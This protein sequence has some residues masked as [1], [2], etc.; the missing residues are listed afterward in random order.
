[1]PRKVLIATPLK[2]DLPKSYFLSSLQL[3]GGKLP[4]VKLDWT[5]LDGPAVQVARNELA[6][7]AIKNGFDE[8]VFWDKDVLAEDELDKNVTSGA[9]V[10]LLEHDV[11]MVCALYANRAV[12]THWHV[13]TIPGVEADEATGLQKVKRCAI[14]FSKIK[15]SALKKV[16]KDNPDRTMLVIDPSNPPHTMTEFFPMGISGK[17]TPEYRIKQIAAAIAELKEGGKDAIP[18]ARL[19]RELTVQYDEP[20]MFLG[21]DYW[22]CEMMRASGFEIYLDTLLVMGH[23]AQVTLPLPTS[24]LIKML[25]EEW[26]QDEVVAIKQ[27]MIAER[28]KIHENETLD[29]ISEAIRQAGKA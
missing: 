11:D 1:M 9:L 5:I 27:A 18:L 16:A 21:E 13:Q 24:K 4:D 3:Y 10:R 25:S 12:M 2:G 23:R 20:N 29:P 14:G 22:F 28:K 17:N 15:V 7:H 19:E 26:R 6:D 8:L